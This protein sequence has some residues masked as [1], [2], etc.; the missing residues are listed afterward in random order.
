MN[1]P[2]SVYAEISDISTAS[3]VGTIKN[4]CY[5]STGM[6]KKEN[7]MENLKKCVIILCAAVVVLALGVVVAIAL[8][9]GQTA[10]TQQ[11][12]TTMTEMLDTLTMQMN[13][14][15]ALF[16]Q[17]AQN[18]SALSA[19]VDV[20]EK[21]TSIMPSVTAATQM[22]TFSQPTTTTAT[23]TAPPTRP[24][25]PHSGGGIFT[26]WGKS[27]CPAT[28]GTSLLYSGLAAGSANDVQGGGANHLCL[29]RDPEYSPG[30]TYINAVNG[31]ATIFGSE[32]ENPAQGRDDDNIPCAVCLLSIRPTVVM[33]PG[34]ATC[35]P[36]WTREYYGYLM[37]E[38][39]MDRNR[40]HRST[41]ECVDQEQESLPAS[42]SNRKAALFYHVEVDCDSLPCPP[43]N[44]HQEVNCV[45]CSK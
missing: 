31:E 25:G 37:A 13:A 4:I 8:S 26:R 41:F 11:T 42:S 19:M 15:D 40:H 28:E 39:D 9:L 10:S 30:L 21:M 18:Q 14:S 32:Y 20:L 23:A 38:R 2:D 17:L 22:G 16:Q 36:A 34:K 35:P 27:S 33:I 43:Y 3:E 7:T 29:P 5:E 12:I 24:P 6:A 44:S 45:V 1:V